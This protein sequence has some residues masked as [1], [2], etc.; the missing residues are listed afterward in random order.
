M[1]EMNISLF[2]KCAMN[3][4]PETTL[5]RASALPERGVL[6]PQ[7]FLHLGIRS[8]VD[9][10]FSR[11]ARAGKRLRGT[12]GVQATTASSRFGS[13]PSAPAKV[14][15]AATE[16]SDEISGPHGASAANA[17][18]LT[19]QVPTRENHLTSGCT[20]KL[21]LGCS[22]ALIKHAPRWMLALGDRPARP[23]APTWIVPT[24]VGPSRRRC[25]V[26]FP[27]PNGRR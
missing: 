17:L 23:R 4:R 18:G 10:A 12:R 6:S 2:E 14:V 22:N 20:R 25:V 1:S 16:Q 15:Q 24:H 27:A 3:A 5:Q 11:L 19:P 9:R 26:P 21:K 8:A 13:H 7:E